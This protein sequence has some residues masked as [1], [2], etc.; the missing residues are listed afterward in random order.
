MRTSIAF[1]LALLSL[2][3]PLPATTQSTAEDRPA[4]EADTQ[5]LH[6]IDAGDY[7]GAWNSAAKAMQAAIPEATFANAISGARTPLGALGTRTLQEAEVKTQLP[8][9]PD[10]H[11]LVAHYLTRFANKAAGIETVVALQ[12][13]DGLW[14]VA[15]YSVR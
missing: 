13:P 5:W 10:G 2:L 11:Y 12:E 1:S 6:L 4:L 8:G 15:G 7:P 14:H 3:A 9:V